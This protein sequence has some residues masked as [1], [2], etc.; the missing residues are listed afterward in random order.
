MEYIRSPQLTAGMNIYDV[1]SNIAE[2]FK[3]VKIKYIPTVEKPIVVIT[4]YYDRYISGSGMYNTTFES[5]SNDAELIYKML[6]DF[7]KSKVGKTIPLKFISSN[8]D[9][10]L[11]GMNK[12]HLVRVANIYELKTPEFKLPKDFIWKD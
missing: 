5:C 9:A 1:L 7:Y 11:Y 3:N 2:I 6:S 10:E 8:I 12:R 4:F